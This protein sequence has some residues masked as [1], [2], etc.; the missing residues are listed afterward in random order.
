MKLRVLVVDDE[1]LSRKVLVMLLQRLGAEEVTV[2]TSF[3]EAVALLS[4]DATFRLVITDHFMPDGRGVGLL[5]KIRQGAL[6][7]PHDTYVIIS[8]TSESF[9]LKAVALALDADAFLTKPYS[10]E[11]LAANMLAFMDAK[12]RTLKPASYYQGLD[13]AGMV[14]AA[15]R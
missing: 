5:G 13:V 9:R 7:V 15:E 10:K 2:A 6:A 14:E 1:A 8:T 12:T 3:G 11:N 4:T